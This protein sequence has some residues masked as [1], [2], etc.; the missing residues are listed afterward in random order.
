MALNHDFILAGAITGTLWFFI[1]AF[2]FARHGKTWNAVACLLIGSIPFFAS[3]WHA[4]LQ[5]AAQR[6]Q[7]RIQSQM[8][9]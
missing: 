5:Q 4:D 1:M 6:E 9:R 7:V 3:A 8:S 2:R